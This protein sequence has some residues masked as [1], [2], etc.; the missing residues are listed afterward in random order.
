MGNYAWV[1]DYGLLGNENNG[2]RFVIGCPAAFILL[3]SSVQLV[4]F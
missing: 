1:G 4:M 3:K 2:K